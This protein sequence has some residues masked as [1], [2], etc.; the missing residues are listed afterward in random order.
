MNDLLNNLAL[1]F[2]DNW[3]AFKLD[4]ENNFITD[5]RW[6]YLVFGLLRTL[7]IDRLHAFYRGLQPSLPILPQR[8]AGDG[9][10]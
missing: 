5:N 2:S 7:E 3:A 8:V 6:Q 4:F 9:A 10:R 1:W